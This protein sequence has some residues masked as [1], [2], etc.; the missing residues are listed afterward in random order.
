MDEGVTMIGEEL[1]EDTDTKNDV[2]LSV[3]QLEGVGA[4]TK[5]KL[6]SF[7]IK[8][9]IDICVRGGKEVSVISG[10]DK[11]KAN[12]WV[13]NSQKILEDNNLIRK[14]DMGVLELM[15]YQD[16][17]DRLITKCKDVDDLFNG[18]VVTEAVYEVYGEFG[19]GK[20]QFCLSLTAEAIAKGENVIWLDCEDTFKPRRLKEILLARELVP[21]EEI[22]QALAHVKY[23]YCPN[24]EQLLGTVD[25]LSEMMLELKPRIVVLDGAIGQ[26]REEYLGRGTLAERQNQIARLMTHI[27]NISFYFRTSVV[28]TNQ[29]QSDPSVMFGDPIKPIGG[30]IVGHASTYRVYFKKSGKK[31]IARM[32]DSPEHEQKDASY[33]LTIKGID[34]LEE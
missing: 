29:V 15:D 9:I 30:N 24:S 10:V 14:S 21:E 19:C 1:I 28:F 8:N 11:I 6:E 22:D 5:K 33:I 27:K 17:Q 18:G 32:I 31:R 23:F 2:D 13:F 16:K 12:A 3:D 34:N 26:F 7:G 20:T 25:S 4:V